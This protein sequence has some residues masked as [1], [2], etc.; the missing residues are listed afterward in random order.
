MGIGAVALVI[1]MLASS[2]LEAVRIAAIGLLLVVGVL[3]S[4]AIV[5]RLEFG[6]PPS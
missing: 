1:T 3:K 2:I 4:P 5:K 6:F